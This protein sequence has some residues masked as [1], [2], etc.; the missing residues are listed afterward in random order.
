MT[1]NVAVISERH[2]AKA[3]ALALTL[4]PVLSLRVPH[5]AWAALLPEI[6]QNSPPKLSLPPIFVRL[7][8]FRI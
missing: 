5:P 3:V 4:L 6:N 8:T 2:N 7:C 1:A